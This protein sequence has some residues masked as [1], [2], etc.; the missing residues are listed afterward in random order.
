MTERE[1]IDYYADWLVDAVGVA[2][3]NRTLLRG[4]PAEDRVLTE[5]LLLNGKK[6]VEL[7]LKAI[8]EKK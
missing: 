6:A 7:A 2:T 4:G 5:A 1:I 3:Q 8:R